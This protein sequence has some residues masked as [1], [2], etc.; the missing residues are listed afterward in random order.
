MSYFLSYCLGCMRII[1]E[2]LNCWQSK[3]EIK[4]EVFHGIKEVGSV[5]YWMGLLD[6]VLVSS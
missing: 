5:L 1:K 6:I 4:A 3:T 2:H